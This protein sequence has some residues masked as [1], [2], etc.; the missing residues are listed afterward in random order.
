LFY[1]S[2]SFNGEKI[3]IERHEYVDGQIYLMAGASKRHNRIARNF[4]NRMEDAAN[5][6]GCEVFFSDVK[7]RIT[8][9][10]TYYYPDVVVSCSADDEADEY[11]LEKPCL[12][13]EVASDSTIS[14]DYME[15]SLAYQRIASLQAYLVVAQDKVQVDMLIRLEDGS[16]GLKQFDRLDGEI[17]LPCLGMVLSVADIYHGVLS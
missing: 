13:V 6:K 16:W 17:E 8:K 4:I 1:K 10:K 7:V 9:Y 14:K 15:K 12:I 2:L 11:Y 3:A 5:S